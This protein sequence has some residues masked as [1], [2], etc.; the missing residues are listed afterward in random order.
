M[1]LAMVSAVAMIVGASG[2][3]AAH[4]WTGFYAGVNLGGAVADAPSDFALAGG[5]VF[6]TAPN[7]LKGAIGGVQ[8]GYGF[9][10]GAL[11]YGFET[12]LQ[13]STA[14]GRQ[15]AS[16][17]CAVVASYGHDV[18]WFGTV[19]GRVG[20]ANDL[21]LAYVTG[22][23]AYARRNTTAR[24]AAFPVDAVATWHDNVHGWTL[25]G[26]VEV[27]VGASWSVKLEYLHADFGSA[28]TTWTPSG[29]P[30][31]SDT[32]DLRMDVVRAGLNYRF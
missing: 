27:G 25:G 3:A 8:A 18:P 22:G 23:Y 32:T 12:D 30:A 6:A 10:S 20:Y 24:A 9:R 1:R 17:G 21:L 15:E 5:P 2:A 28:T 13:F 7:T 11:A 26:G 29:L 31:I 16:C 4:D 19:R 14:E